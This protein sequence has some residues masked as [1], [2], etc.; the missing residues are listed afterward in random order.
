MPL[1]RIRI[2]PKLAQLVHGLTLPLTDLAVSDLRNTRP[3]I[4]DSLEGSPRSAKNMPRKIAQGIRQ[5]GI[6]GV[7]AQIRKTDHFVR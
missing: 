7:V 6:R 4:G 2:P 5:S 3:V 1:R